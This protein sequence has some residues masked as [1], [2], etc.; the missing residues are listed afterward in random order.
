MTLTGAGRR[1]KYANTIGSWL[2]CAIFCENDQSQW[3]SPRGEYGRDAFF[4]D[5]TWCHRQSGQD[6]YCQK[7][8]CLPEGYNINE[9]VR[10]AESLLGTETESILLDNSVIDVL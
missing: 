1:F 5:G 10:I 2:S 6:Y 9:A 3:Y 4:P 7:N 8:L